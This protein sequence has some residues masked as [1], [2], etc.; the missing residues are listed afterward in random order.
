MSGAGGEPEEPV[1]GL[2]TSLAT[3]QLSQ[4]NYGNVIVS[5]DGRVVTTL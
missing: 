2:V 4:P 1:G 5:A 3:N